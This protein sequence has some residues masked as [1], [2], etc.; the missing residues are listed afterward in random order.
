ML[1]LCCGGLSIT[2]VSEG[3]EIVPVVTMIES[4]ARRGGYNIPKKGYMRR[5]AQTRTTTQDQR[6]RW[7][8]PAGP[9]GLVPVKLARQ[10]G[11]SCRPDGLGWTLLGGPG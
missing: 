2:L 7:A 5:L 4:R 8:G 9:G 11:R 3:Q 6:S 10:D 1:G